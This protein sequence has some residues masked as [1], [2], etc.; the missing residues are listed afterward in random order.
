MMLADMGS[1]NVSLAPILGEASKVTVINV[2][3]YQVYHGH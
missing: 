1:V 3:S 2:F